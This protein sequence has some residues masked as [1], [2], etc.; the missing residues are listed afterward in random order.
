MKARTSRSLV[1]EKNCS[2]LKTPLGILIWSKNRTDHKRAMPA[3]SFSSFWMFILNKRD[4]K[5]QPDAESGWYHPLRSSYSMTSLRWVSLPNNMALWGSRTNLNIDG[6]PAKQSLCGMAVIPIANIRGNLTI[7]DRNHIYSISSTW[8]K[9]WSLSSK[10]SL[11][12]L[13]LV[14]AW[15]LSW[16]L[17][18]AVC[19]LSSFPT[20]R[21]LSS[22]ICWSISCRACKMHDKQK[23]TRLLHA[24]NKL[25]TWPIYIFLLCLVFKVSF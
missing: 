13:I 4:I 2:L 9:H 15:A 11:D 20:R 3:I 8:S 16:I 1:P 6:N 18:G 12:V 25:Q 22:A 17:W 23:R 14:D 7:I 10:C 24:S 5:A 21:S 19:F